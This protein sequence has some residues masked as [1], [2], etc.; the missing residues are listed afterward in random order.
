MIVFK[1]LDYLL[2]NFLN[3]KNKEIFMVENIK[4]PVAYKDVKK[5]ERIDAFFRK[6]EENQE[7]SR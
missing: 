2:N 7:N 4:Y 3:Q 1:L 6:K 5:N